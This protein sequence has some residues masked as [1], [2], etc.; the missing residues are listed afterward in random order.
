[1]IAAKYCYD[2]DIPIL[3]LCCGQNVM[4]RALG[5]TT[6]YVFNPEKH[7]NKKDDYAHKVF[8]KKNTYL[9]KI[10]GK[11]EIMVNSRHKKTVDKHPS[12]TINC[13][14]VEAA[15]KK[16]YIALRFH[17]ESLYKFDENHNKI[18]K[19]FI[20]VCKKEKQI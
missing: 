1:M 15:N 12:L 3:G 14:C 4:V 19:E 11:D 18:F 13:T 7:M 9:Y 10:I 5:G 17:S 2:N 20:N 8:I 6:K 16:F